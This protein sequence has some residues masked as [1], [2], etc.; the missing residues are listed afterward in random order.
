MRRFFAGLRGRLLLPVPVMVEV[1]WLLEERPDIEA[2][3]LDSVEQDVFELASLTKPDVGRI[4]ELV[5]QYADFPLGA[6]DASVLAV[7]ERFG[8][9]RVATLDRKHFGV[10]RPRHVQS[11]TLLP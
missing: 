6:V 2:A 9:D 10:V 5:R 11:L 7:A 4:A 8:T 1:C 3:F